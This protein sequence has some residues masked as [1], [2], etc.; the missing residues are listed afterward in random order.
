MV[1]HG[2]PTEP[3]ER[4][5]TSDRRRPALGVGMKICVRNRFLGDWSMGFEVAD[6]LGDGY[7]IRRIS[8]GLCFPDVFP[9]DDVRLERRQ[10][11]ERGVVGSCL[12]REG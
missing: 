9:L 11:P 3:V 10:D 5:E 12:D 1:N 7:R 4:V 2:N 6:V 8:D